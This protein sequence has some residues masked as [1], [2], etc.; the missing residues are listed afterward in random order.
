MSIQQIKSGVIAANSV[1]SSTIA[2]SAIIQSKLSTAVLPI[3]VG[4]TWQNV[5]SERVT[6]VNYTNNTGRPIFV[7][8][9]FYNEGGVLKGITVDGVLIPGT[10]QTTGAQNESSVGAIVPNGSTYSFTAVSY[11]AIHIRELR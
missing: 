7:V 5:T 9:A 11:N 6:G 2:D 1:V 10:A 3:G 4:Q 8:F